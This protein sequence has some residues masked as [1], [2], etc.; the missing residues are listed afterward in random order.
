[1][2]EEQENSEQGSQSGEF[3]RKQEEEEQEQAKQ[4]SERESLRKK[5]LQLESQQEE[6]YQNSREKH[7]ELFE[8]AILVGLTSESLPVPEGRELQSVYIDRLNEI[9]LALLYEELRQERLKW[10][11]GYYDRQDKKKER[12]KWDQRDWRNELL[13]W[14]GAANLLIR[15]RDFE[16]SSIFNKAVELKMR[17]KQLTG[18]FKEYGPIPK[19]N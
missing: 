9:E 8:D 11:S 16:P 5:R 10:A 1:M 6:H 19:K 12:A 7:F 13:K 15:T 18:E 2:E 17:I 3:R 4:E 14:R